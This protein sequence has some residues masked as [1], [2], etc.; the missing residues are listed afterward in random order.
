MLCL[1]S[2]EHTFLT[3]PANN[4]FSLQNT[5]RKKDF[6][7]TVNLSRNGSG[8]LYSASNQ[9]IPGCPLLFLRKLRFCQS[10]ILEF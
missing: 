1:I 3:I 2:T 5:N 9:S 10:G 7:S 8:I 4:L 6:S